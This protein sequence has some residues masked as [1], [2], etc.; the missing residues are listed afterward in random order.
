MK[1][2]PDPWQPSLWLLL[3]TLA[4]GVEQKA[5]GFPQAPAAPRTN[6]L[7]PSEKQGILPLV[8]ETALLALLLPLELSPGSPPKVVTLGKTSSK[9]P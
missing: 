6:L 7:F 2:L 8:P 3:Q 1:S 9:L 4:Q 5:D